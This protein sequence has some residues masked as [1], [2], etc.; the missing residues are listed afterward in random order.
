MSL[1]QQTCFAY[2]GYKTGDFPVS[3]QAAAQTL[4]LPVYPELRP[5]QVA[6]VVERIGEFVK[7]EG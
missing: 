1:H 6:F 5:E 4:A 3:E 2:L 7:K